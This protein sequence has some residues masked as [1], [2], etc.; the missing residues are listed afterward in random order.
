MKKLNKAIALVAIISPVV[1]AAD[2]ISNGSFESGFSGWT[3]S[4]QIGSDGTFSLQS[5][6]TSPVNGDP[7]PAPPNGSKAAMT[8][9]GGPGSHILYQDF[10]VPST[11]SSAALQ[12]DLFVGNRA[13]RFVSPPTLDFAAIDNGNAVLNQQAR[14]D[15]LQT[16]ADPFSVAASDVLLTAY[17]TQPGD[18]LISGYNHIAHDI[19]GVLSAHLGETLRLRFAETDN[20][21][22]FQLGVDNASIALAESTSRVPDSGGSSLA[23]MMVGGLCWAGRKVRCS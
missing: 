9:A 19:T 17:Q 5:G 23:I 20:L 21:S 10:V 7:V 8:D 2:L 12:F 16:G 1:Q 22:I 11:L 3:R 14:V 6:T 18:A 13:D 15:I 4:D